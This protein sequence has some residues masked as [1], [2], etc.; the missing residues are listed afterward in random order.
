[1]IA[2][3]Y[4][5]FPWLRFSSPTINEVGIQRHSD[6][7]PIICN[8][9]TINSDGTTGP[10]GPPG[11]QGEQGPPGP[12]GDVGPQGPQGLTGPQ[13]PIG[14]T[15]PQGPKGEQGAV[16]PPGPP[17]PEPERTATLVVT[18]HVIN[19]PPSPGEVPSQAPD[20]II[21]VDGTNVAPSVFPGSESGFTVKL[22]P[23]PYAVIEL[24][25]EPASFQYNAQ[26]SADCIGTISAGETKMCT[27][28]NNN[29]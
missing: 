14:P 6:G 2:H 28:T 22:A 7:N 13:G 5:Y 8:R 9:C 29:T 15:G 19:D 26:Y 10:S 27:V 20:F 17:E 16:G 1:M 11:P 3:L 21:M 12:Q 4:G 18:K 25:P 23:G 24:K